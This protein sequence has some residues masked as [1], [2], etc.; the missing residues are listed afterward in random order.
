MSAETTQ[1]VLGGNQPSYRACD[2][3]QIIA[4]T[5]RWHRKSA[6]I[7]KSYFGIDLV[8]LDY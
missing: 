2:R 8:D 7:G 5:L 1:N 6:V 4:P 3:T